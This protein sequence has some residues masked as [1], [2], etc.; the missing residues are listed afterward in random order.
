MFR[1]S[2]TVNKARA[3]H[4]SQRRHEELRRRAVLRRQRDLL[5]ASSN[6][7]GLSALSGT[8]VYGGSAQGTRNPGVYSIAASGPTSANYDITY[9]DGRL[10]IIPRDAG[11]C[12]LG[13]AATRVLPAHS[14]RSRRAARVERPG[15]DRGRAA[16]ST[17]SGTISYAGKGV[18]RY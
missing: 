9:V 18:L 16:L 4:C 3:H 14:A 8:L 11:A 6:G 10:A 15:A 7:E 13:A 5:P 2:L 12:S 17:G 1:R